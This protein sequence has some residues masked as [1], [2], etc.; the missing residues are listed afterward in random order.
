MER[1]LVGTVVVV[2]FPYSGY[3][4]AKKRPALCIGHSGA[5]DVI[6]CQ[7][8]SQDYH[9]EKSIVLIEKDDFENGGLPLDRSYIR[10][11]KIFTF[12]TNKIL[13]TIGKIS[14]NALG[15]VG[16]KLNSIFQE[17]LNMPQ[18]LLR[19]VEKGT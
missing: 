19:E 8:T 3:S 4:G 11:D 14:P 16:I 13:R 1:P 12:E 5:T 2:E 9:R 10:P 6:L 15:R 18:V 7:I 17:V